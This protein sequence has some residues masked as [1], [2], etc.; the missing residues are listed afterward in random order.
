MRTSLWLM[1]LGT[2]ATV[3]SG[4]LPAGAEV[5]SAQPAANLDPSQL[6]AET[7]QE[8]L[9]TLEKSPTS[10]ILAQ[11]AGS[12]QFGN[13][14]TPS[15][16]RELLNDL[17]PIL[18]VRKAPL[19]TPGI[20]FGTPT[21]YGASW[22]QAFVGTS[23]VI[24][25]GGNG[26]RDD[27]SL[28]V[29]I[30][31]GDAIETVGLETSL[32]ITSV[33]ANDFGDSG[34]VG[35]K[36]HKIIPDTK[37]LALAVGWATALDWGDTENEPETVYGVASK[38]FVLRPNNNNTF[39]LT[40]SIGV[41][42][43]SFRSTGAIDAGDNT[44]NVFGSLGVVLIPQV[45]LATSWTGNKWNLGMGLAPFSVPLT[46]TLGFTDLTD[47]SIEGPGFNI[48]AGYAIRF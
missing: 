31:F 34:S 37:G 28:S 43:G 33:S 8:P 10:P 38:T 18:D 13:T 47:N 7:S 20:T 48:N 5:P 14:F 32:S 36:L 1:S 9:F 22:R 2:I 44:P 4:N 41:G 6:A 26:G 3:L 16:S 45:S 12:D 23:G 29:G 30:G 42:T 46:F 19:P 25:F 15:E 39:P 40:A 17:V 27:G 11:S 24:D 35:F 21:A